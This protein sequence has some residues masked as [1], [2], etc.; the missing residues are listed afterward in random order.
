MEI[1]TQKEYS[2]TANNPAASV[3]AIIVAGGSS[4]RMKG[5]DKLFAELM[6]KPVLAHTLLAY[7]GCPSVSKIVVAARPDA[8]ADVQKLCRQYEISKVTAVVE[9]GATR[10]ESVKNAVEAVDDDCAYLAIADGARPLTS[11]HDIEATLE[12]AVRFGAAA[13]AVKVTD[14]IKVTDTDNF[15][16]GTPDRS[17]LWAAQTPQIFRADRYKQALSAHFGEFTDDCAIMEADG[18]K[19]KLVEGSYTNI[20]ITTPTDLIIAQA[21]LTEGII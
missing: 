15:I 9:G 1:L 18:V 20:K 13:C 17:S 19:V 10:A 21:F 2:F 6:G 8:I 11:K 5:I 12:A 14:T 16:K 3:T 4:A 7:Q